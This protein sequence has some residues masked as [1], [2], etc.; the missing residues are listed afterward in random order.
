MWAGAREGGRGRAREGG[1]KGTRAKVYPLP[2]AVFKALV[3]IDFH[4]IA[5]PRKGAPASSAHRYQGFICGSGKAEEQG[6]CSLTQSVLS[7]CLS[8]DGGEKP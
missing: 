8:P 2:L 7:V 6:R 3:S 1:R 4:L 5:L